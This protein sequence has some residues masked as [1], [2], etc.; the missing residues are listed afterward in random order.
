MEGRRTGRGLDVLLCNASVEGY[1][2]KYNL[3]AGKEKNSI[4]NFNEL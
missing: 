3:Y 4:D 2:E 1:L